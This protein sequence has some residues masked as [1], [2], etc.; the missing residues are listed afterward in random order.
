MKHSIR[1]RLLRTF[2]LLL[3]ALLLISGAFTFAGMRFLRDAARE[4]EALLG[5]HASRS[6]RAMMVSQALDAAGSFVLEKAQTINQKLDS[7]RRASAEMAAYA[8]YLYEHPD[9]FQP[10]PVPTPDE[11]QAAGKAD[12]PVLHYLPATKDVKGPEA[13]AENALLGNLEAMFSAMY[14]NIPEI[15]SIYTAD[16]SGANIGYDQNASLKT[17]IGAFDCRNLEWYTS[18]KATQKAYFSKAYADSF[19]RG[20]T[21]TLA[22]PILVGGAFSGV[23]GVD[24]LIENINGEI[25]NTRY[26]AG[27]YAMLFDS[28][29]GVISA[30][31]L[32]EENRQSAAFLGTGAEAALSAMRLSES[33]RVESEIG[34]QDVYILYAPVS[35]AGWKLAVVMP[36]D[37]M[38]K[39]A[40][41]ADEAIR[42]IGEKALKDMDGIINR[43]NLIM[44][45]LFLILAAVC[46]ILVRRVCENVAR[47][48]LA[49]AKDVG[50]IGEGNLDYHS[51]IHTGDEI[52][53]LGASFERMTASL[54]SYIENL[55]RVTAERERLGAELNVAK[56]IQASMLPCIF[57]PFPDRPEFDLYATM[58]P[59]KEVGGDF[60][61][62][63]MVDGDHLTMVIADVSGKG[64]PAALFMMTSKTLLQTL[65]QTGLSP[66]EV[67]SEANAKLCENNE[68]GMFV[69]VWIGMLEISSGRFVYANAGHNAPL[70]RRNG[71]AFEFLQAR[72]GFVLAGM[73]GVRYHQEETMLQPGD[74]LY[75]YTDGV[76]EAADPKER[77]YG[78]ERLRK[79]I[80][81]SGSG[82]LKALLHGVKVDI[83][84]FADGAEQSDDITMLALRIDRRGRSM[85]QLTV[86]A[87]RDRLDDVLAFIEGELLAAGCP[88]KARLQLSLAA[89]EVFVNIADYAYGGGEGEATVSMDVSGNP[90]VATVIFSDE[91][92]P[93]DPLEKQD[94]DVTLP[95]DDREIG[96]LGI[97]LMKKSVDEVRYRREDGRNLLTLTKALG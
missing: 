46:V 59:A 77:L 41:Q 95:V 90:P 39:P 37:E 96:G 61:D 80:D 70:L 54:K 63:F 34:G 58:V 92:A 86:P 36:V 5:D 89:E 65:A 97:F 79:T 3:C 6:S 17:G 84:A 55:T 88:A 66:A 69:T 12:G 52:E 68:A 33:G 64:I 20:L 50:G 67:L 16:E 18:V 72:P 14:S 57:P 51:G 28:D 15:S 45:G 40:A 43:L 13:E 19:G 23:L 62:F 10:H 48:I 21:V 85:K 30:K 56:R 83:D 22:Q 24:L 26:G 82:D 81:Q 32:S 78:E 60:Y 2:L 25:L 35:V 73:E 1:V 7:F 4:S 94:P 91:G 49:L 42:E 38:L 27:G 75:L 11:L 44:L 53:A 29:G 76:T 9:R 47:P 31:G 71:G 93:H 74:L 87:R 8:A